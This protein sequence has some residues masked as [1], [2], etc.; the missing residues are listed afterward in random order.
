MKLKS[1][2]FLRGV[3]VS[4]VVYA[5]SIDLQEDHSISFQQNFYYLENFGAIG[6]DLFFVISGFIISYIASEYNGIEKGCLF[7]RKR[8]LRINPPY[9]IASLIQIII[10]LSFTRI[11]N[12]VLL[13][14]IFDTIFLFPIWDGKES[15]EPILS[16]G[17]TLSFEWW[18]YLIFFITISF[19]IKKKSLC[20]IIVFIIITTLGIFFA[21]HDTR[22]IFFLNPILLEFTI[23]ILVFNLYNTFKVN[24][25]LS[26]FLL[27]IGLIGYMLNIRLGYGEISE[28]NSIIIDNKGLKRTLLWGIPSGFIVMGSIYLERHD[29]LTKL[30][31]N[32]L[33]LLLG[34]ASFSIYLIH[35]PVFYLIAVYYKRYG[36][37]IIPD[38]SILLHLCLS[39]VIGIF[40]YFWIERKLLITFN[41]A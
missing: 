23:G 14:E 9:Y 26:Y 39:L 22:M 15:L 36:F 37:Y 4:L 41:L 11:S 8:F 1:I 32:N 38:L 31:N 16:V 13:N 5:H 29:K 3:A 6:A 17:W 20:L 21:G 19:G 24:A 7:L 2:Q 34:N 30:W 10:F 28:L 12:D 40:F 33:G 18:F 25:S 27:L 35:I